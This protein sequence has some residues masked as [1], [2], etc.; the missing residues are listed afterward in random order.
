[1]D[2]VLFVHRTVKRYMQDLLNVVV[3]MEATTGLHQTPE[4]QLARGLLRPPGM[5]HIDLLMQQP[6]SFLGIHQ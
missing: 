4:P 6:Y 2:H 5:L 1:M 3:M